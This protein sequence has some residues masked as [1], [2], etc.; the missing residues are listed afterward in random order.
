MCNVLITNGQ[1]YSW[2]IAREALGISLRYSY[3]LMHV[4]I[5][6]KMF[7]TTTHG[8]VLSSSVCVTLNAAFSLFHC[9]RQL[10]FASPGPI[11]VS[12]VQFSAWTCQRSERAV[13][14]N[15]YVIHFDKQFITLHCFPVSLE[16]DVH[17]SIQSTTGDE[18]V[19][20][21]QYTSQSVHRAMCNYQYIVIKGYLD[22]FRGSYTCCPSVRR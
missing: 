17:N 21:M 5:G 6:G 9:H 10:T 18:E 1:V 20:L 4:F 13:R 7:D 8:G 22:I 14:N 12:V 2:F 16:Y 11:T 19:I 3:L 15:S